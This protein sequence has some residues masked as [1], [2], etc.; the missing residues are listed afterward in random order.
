MTFSG[1]RQILE[2]QALP[3]LRESVASHDPT[4]LDRG[5]PLLQISVSYRQQQLGKLMGWLEPALEARQALECAR[6]RGLLLTEELADAYAAEARQALE[7]LG[8]GEPDSY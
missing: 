5:S 4:E 1:R 2:G 8:N 3:M 6:I 7:R